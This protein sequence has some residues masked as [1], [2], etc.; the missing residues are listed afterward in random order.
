ITRS[1]RAGL[2]VAAAAAVA[3]AGVVVAIQPSGQQ[4]LTV[5]LLADR[6]AA[7]ALNGP[8][9]LAGQW[10]YERS[11][12]YNG[13][14]QARGFPNPSFQDGW[15]TADGTLNYGAGSIGDPIFPYDK[16][17]SLPRDPAALIRYFR[18]LDPVASDDNSLVEFSKIQEMLFGMIL[19]PWLQAEMYHALALIPYV[20]I[21]QD[22]KDIA[23]R[24]G[25]AFLLPP[26]KQSEQEEIILDASDY[27]LL[28]R[29]SWDNPSDAATI[30]ET[31]ILE[32]VLVTELGST[33]PA[34]AP[35]SAAEVAA[36]RLVWDGSNSVNPPP[37]YTPDQ[38]LYRD[39]RTGGSDRQV[40]ATADDTIQAQYVNGTLQVCKRTDPCATSEQW[41]MPAGPSYTL[42]YPA[43]TKP[44]LPDY[45]RPLLDKLNSYGTGC[46]DVAGDCDAV[47]AVANM[48]TGY[49]NDQYNASS[50]FLALADVP[51]VSIQQVTDSAGQ[52]VTEFTFPFRDGVTGILVSGG[53]HVP[54]GFHYAGY[55]RDGQQTL[56]MNQALVSGPGVLPAH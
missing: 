40:W 53:V 6:A 24:D 7:A 13:F 41:L 9:V 15:M 43:R 44:T 50:W 52:Q 31:A 55:V 22:V 38:W 48:L 29:A 42:I 3:T 33:Q 14:R 34:A 30:N 11:E 39:L 56:V 28:A 45:P 35:P 47:N 49:G 20:Q 18:Q 12:H 17:D 10:V 8:N 1:W 51:G 36:E 37:R 27:H 19:P 16:I 4:P 5:Q 54:D 23:G 2:S 21:R 25:V 46:T 26:T 32:S